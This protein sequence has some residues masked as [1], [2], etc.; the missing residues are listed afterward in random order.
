[1]AAS[2]AVGDELAPG[3][4]QNGKP[5]EQGCQGR[6]QIGH[7]DR[8]SSAAATLTAAKLSGRGGDVD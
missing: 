2:T 8:G 3:K 4:W 7:G 6:W 5:E 1:M